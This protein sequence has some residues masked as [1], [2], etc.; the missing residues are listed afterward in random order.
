MRR[1]F[2]SGKVSKC[3]TKAKALRNSDETELRKLIN[4]SAHKAARRLVD[5]ET[6][7]VWYWPAA[8]G[9]LREGA[10]ALNL[11]CS[12]GQRQPKVQGLGFG[13]EVYERVRYSLRVLCLIED[14]A[15][16]INIVARGFSLTYPIV[17]NVGFRTS[18]RF[19]ESVIERR[20]PGDRVRRAC[21]GMSGNFIA[22]RIRR[23]WR[24]FL[25]LALDLLLLGISADDCDLFGRLGL[26]C[27]KK[28]GAVIVETGFARSLFG[29][30]R[31]RRD[32]RGSSRIWL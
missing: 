17:D 32:L 1:A 3:S 6:G 16:D 8:I 12:R 26:S 22:Y 19:K 30:V 21:G 10:D 7:D 5:E 31:Q 11:T 29:V 27:G 25:L 24:G 2:I 15:Q 28:C 13:D 14:L 4:S 23:G 18:I 20:S 9:T